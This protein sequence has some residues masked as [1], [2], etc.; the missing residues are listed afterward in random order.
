MMEFTMSRPP[1]TTSLAL[2]MYPPAGLARSSTGPTISCIDPALPA[3]HRAT[4]LAA[5]G[6]VS[7]KS[8]RSGW[9]LTPVIS[10]GNMPGRME[11]TRIL[12]LARFS[13]VGISAVTHGVKRDASRLA[14]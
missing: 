9:E 3:G 7:A 13:W 2:F 6:F 4:A 8:L 11:L 12:R 5:W 10:E 14:Q 1:S